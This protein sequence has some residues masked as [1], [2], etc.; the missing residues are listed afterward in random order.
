MQATPEQQRIATQAIADTVRQAMDSKEPPAADA[1]KALATSTAAA[2][3]AGIQALN[4][5]I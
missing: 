1:I 4:G 3:A 5:A 2:L